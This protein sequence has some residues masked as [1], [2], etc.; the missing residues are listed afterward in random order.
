MASGPFWLYV[1]LVPIVVTLPPYTY[2]A[3]QAL[4]FPNLND[5]C[6]D[7]SYWKELVL[8][9]LMDAEL[10]DLTEKER[11][12]LHKKDTGADGPPKPARQ[13]TTMRDALA[14]VPAGSMDGG[15]NVA[16]WSGRKNLTGKAA[17]R[18][19]AR[20][21]LM[22]TFMSEEVK[23]QLNIKDKLKKKGSDFLAATKAAVADQ[24]LRTSAQFK[25]ENPEEYKKL[26]E[27]NEAE[28]AAAAE[29]APAEGAQEA[30]DVLTH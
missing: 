18:K 5:K 10:G 28:R 30:S 17:I 25:E 15:D 6:R 19:A 3:V 14:Q 26:K 11:M 2:R 20:Q 12:E 22:Q 7:S 24:E 8:A 4:Y 27:S 1:A 16:L 23:K 21:V 13:G 29:A 9:G